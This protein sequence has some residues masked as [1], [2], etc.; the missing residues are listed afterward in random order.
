MN[1]S[2]RNEA[3]ESEIYNKVKNLL[4]KNCLLKK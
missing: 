2:S 1:N 4:Q 3:D